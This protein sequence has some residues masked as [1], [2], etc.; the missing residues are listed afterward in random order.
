MSTDRVKIE[1]GWSAPVGAPAMPEAA[2]SPTSRARLE[3]GLGGA[4]LRTFE[5]KGP[6]ALVFG[7]AILLAVGAFFAFAFTVAVGI[8]AA[9][10]AGGAA[11]GAL[12]FG[13]ARVRRRFGQRGPRELDE[14][15]KKP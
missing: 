2:D 13:A 14:P 12:G 9:L 1:G 4:N 10:A 15:S 3:L 11:L 8:G 7:L 6:L 5:V